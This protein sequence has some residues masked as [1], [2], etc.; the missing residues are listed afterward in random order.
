[1]GR[2][3]SS[4]PDWRWAGET[5]D[6]DCSNWASAALAEAGS[7][8]FAPKNPQR[9][10]KKQLPKFKLKASQ[11]QIHLDFESEARS[12]WS[13]LL[14]GVANPRSSRRGKDRT[15]LVWLL[16]V[17]GGRR[18]R[19]VLRAGRKGWLSRRRRCG[20]CRLVWRCRRRC[21]GPL[22]AVGLLRR[23]GR[24]GSG[25]LLG[26]GRRRWCGVRSSA[27]VGIERWLS[28]GRWRLSVVRAKIRLRRQSSSVG[29]EVGCDSH[30]WRWVGRSGDVGTGRVGAG[31]GEL[32]GLAVG[33]GWLGGGG[34]RE[35]D[36]RLRLLLAV[37]E[38]GQAPWRRGWPFPKRRSSSGG[39][40]SF[41]RHAEKRMKNKRFGR[42]VSWL[43]DRD[44]R[45]EGI[46]R[47]FPEA[48]PT[49][50]HHVNSRIPRLLLSCISDTSFLLRCPA[51]A[52]LSSQP[53]SN[54][55]IFLH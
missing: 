17:L 49:S 34:G 48:S 51:P 1:M 33:S 13:I 32:V 10:A 54:F 35:S 31:P 50:L 29:A 14:E 46:D 22:R 44:A 37:I 23:W 55:Y 24:R 43:P 41:S 19:C 6:S 18:W 7:N 38:D 25:S 5:G 42:L 47:G 45:L 30:G 53:S 40:E 4:A 11:T 9:T 28:S 52:P 16:R 3:V 8:H 2:M 21:R 27:V 36:G 12:V 39:K 26:V 15:V 20:S